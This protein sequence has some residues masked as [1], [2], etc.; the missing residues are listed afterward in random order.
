MNVA[1]KDLCEEL[2]ELSGW[3]NTEYGYGRKHNHS[4]Q[5]AIN[6]W[7]EWTLQPV[8]IKTSAFDEYLPAHNLGYL[9]R[10]LPYK[11]KDECQFDQF[12]VHLKQ[13]G[14]GGWTIYY[15]E[16]GKDSEMYFNGADTPEDAACKL[17]IELWKQGILTKDKPCKIEN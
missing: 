16:P 17:A 13:T 14:G 6:M 7:G 1:S 5:L 3:D 15:G 2:Y 10:K 11:V 8:H 4:A 12:G 9:L